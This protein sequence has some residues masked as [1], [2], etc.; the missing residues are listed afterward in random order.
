MVHG[1]F[2]APKPKQ[3]KDGERKLDG[4]RRIGKWTHAK[5]ICDVNFWGLRVVGFS[6][7]LH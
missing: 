1:S 2:C 5:W 6:N 3:K 4:S 7:R